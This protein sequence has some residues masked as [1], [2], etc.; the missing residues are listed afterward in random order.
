MPKKIVRKLVK[1]SELKAENKEPEVIEIESDSSERLS[2]IL[3][4]LEVQK[5]VIAAKMT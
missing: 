3:T 2:D 4:C 1:L 5:N